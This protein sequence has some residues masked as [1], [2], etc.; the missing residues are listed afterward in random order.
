MYFARKLD[1]FLDSWF[2]DAHR[3]P[4]IVKGARQVGKTSSI[5]AFAKRHFASVIEIN[6]VEHPEYKTILCEGLGVEAVVKQISIRDPSLRFAVGETLLFF[7]EIQEF[8]EITATLKF[9]CEDGRYAVICSGSLLGV[10][11]KRISSYSVGYKTD[12][13]MRGLDFEEY[14][15]VLG[16]GANVIDDLFAHLVEKHPFSQTELD[17]FGGHF[18]DFSILGGMPEVVAMF[19]ETKRF[20]GTLERQRQLLDEYRADARKYNE[21]LDQARILAVFD[22]IAGQLAKENKKF[23]ISKVAH[24]AR[25]RDYFGCVTWLC[26]AGIVMPC[27]C[28]NFPELPLKGNFDASRYKLYMGDTGLLVAQLDDAAQIDL[29]ANRNFGVYKG[30]LYENIVAE[31]LV[32]SGLDLFYYRREDST[33]EED[34]F[35]RSHDALVPVE[36]KATKGRSKSLR[37]LIESSHYPDISWGLKLHAGNVGFE[38]KIFSMPY[39]CTFL[40]KRMLEEESWADG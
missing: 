30:A 5:R 39:F 25:T 10:H 4:L 23:Q 16:Y 34:F 35:V 15:N 3:K 33:L 17:V 1:A 24:G 27:Y 40:L 38:N 20:E 36:V 12:V 21:G 9:F 22:S 14:L 11:E 13:V 28:L 6:F 18:R 31:G 8:P 2:A 19:A 26:D 29:R 7:D 32:K 37:M